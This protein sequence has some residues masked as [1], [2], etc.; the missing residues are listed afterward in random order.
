M[1]VIFL[2][3]KVI[4]LDID[5]VLQVNSDTR[6]E[7]GLLFHKQ[8]EDN[9]SDIIKQT[10]AQIVISSTWK[11]SGVSI[12]Q[13]MWK[14]RNLPGKV[15]DITPDFKEVIASRGEEIEEWLRNNW[16]DSYCIIDD[17]DAMLPEQLPYLVQTSKNYDHS[18]NINGYGLT[19]ECANKVIKIL[20]T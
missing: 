19:R 9:L 13:K 2:D 17:T 8:F 10:D 4:F 11:S 5:G 14:K 20:N 15:I 12:L 6:D 16:V 7:F 3:I 18:Q 1:K